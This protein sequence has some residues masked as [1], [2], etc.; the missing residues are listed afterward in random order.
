MPQHY[1]DIERARKKARGLSS[2]L[3]KRSLPLGGKP[4]PL[5]DYIDPSGKLVKQNGETIDLSVFPAPGE[6]GDL[7]SQTGQNP[8]FAPGTLAPGAGQPALSDKEA[9]RRDM[10]FWNAMGLI[11]KQTTT[12]REDAAL[13]GPVGTTSPRQDMASKFGVR[14]A[15]MSEEEFQDLVFELE[16]K[17][18]TL[19]SPRFPSQNIRGLPGPTTDSRPMTDSPES[20]VFRRLIGQ[21]DSTEMERPSPGR[22]A[23]DPRA[24]VPGSP[25]SN[26]LRRLLGQTGTPPTTTPSIG[27]AY[28]EDPLG[29]A[30]GM[31]QSQKETGQ[32]IVDAFRRGDRAAAV[33]PQPGLVPTDVGE[34]PV[35]DKSTAQ[36]IS[37]FEAALKGGIT[38]APRVP[39]VPEVPGVPGVPG[40]TEVTRDIEN[41]EESVRTNRPLA[42]DIQ[43]SG[44][45]STSLLRA[46]Y[47]G[48]Y[49]FNEDTILQNRER[50]LMD[51]ID[52]L[53]ARATTLAATGDADKKAESLALEGEVDALE[54]RIISLQNFRKSLRTIDQ[55]VTTAQEATRTT[56]QA[57]E[58]EQELRQAL[59]PIFTSLFPNIDSSLLSAI[60]GT[61][62]T[63]MLPELFK[64]IE[65]SQK[66]R[67]TD[68]SMSELIAYLFP[69]IPEEARAAITPTILSYLLMQRSPET[70]GPRPLA[71]TFVR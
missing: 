69:Q 2:S 47:D 19:R 31:G 8:F 30:Q 70:Q 50:F 68:L 48:I 61:T 42:Q 3:A 33:T 15:G 62:L 26:F 58:R 10:E 21:Q 17:R 22:A 53:T 39:E 59:A 12:Y 67:G 1:A 44:L 49:G 13:A 57:E 28:I 65:S 18:P 29:F 63:A 52:S 54:K 40:V 32:R 27:P 34:V 24:R 43:S 36:R 64:S 20:N 60:P 41:V 23:R 51:Q 11:P 14:T 7:Y 6:P 5:P 25:E 16:G 46:A 37:E 45:D 55:N 9:V 71:T 38:R 56:Q 35:I 66:Q 4:I